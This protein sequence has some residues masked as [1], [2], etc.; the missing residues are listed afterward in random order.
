M[1]LS[2]AAPLR[3]EF[4][5]LQ[6]FVGLLRRE[7]ALLT[8]GNIE[9]LP[10]LTAEKSA[11]AGRLGQLSGDRER[12]APTPGMEGWQS[13]VDL[14][15]EARAL[16]ETNGKLIA[17]RMQHNQRALAI[18][19]AAADQDVVYGPDGQQRMG[20]GRSFGSA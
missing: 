6:A 8:E 15:A 19:M 10:L 9:A 5:A 17:L 16:N 13:L 20:S 11:L 3:E 4:E 18:L 12:A 1:P 2:V 14:A 7:Q